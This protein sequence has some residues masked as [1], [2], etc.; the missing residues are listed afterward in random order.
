MV[1]V[2]D[3]GNAATDVLRGYPLWFP[4]ASL[5]PADIAA[6]I[7]AG[8]QAA[9]TATPEVRAQAARFADRYA[10]DNQLLPRVDALL[11]VA[12]ER[13]EQEST[14]EARRG[15]MKAVLVVGGRGLRSQW[16][17]SAHDDLAVGG[18]PVDITLVSWHLPAEPLPVRE[19][20]VIGPRLG[21]ARRHE[22]A[23]PGALGAVEPHRDD[24]TAAQADM[25]PAD[26]EQGGAPVPAPPET[27]DTSFVDDETTDQRSA[28]TPDSAWSARRVRHGLTW[29]AK[30]V[31]LTGRR[32]Y[33]GT[34]GDDPVSRAM[35]TVHAT[36]LVQR[37]R[38]NSVSIK[39]AI[40]V[41][42]VP[43]VLAAVRE[44]DVLVGVDGNSHRAVW[45]LARKV[46]GPPVVVGLPSARKVLQGRAQR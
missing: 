44:A 26:S 23:P 39:F 2:H 13:V 27:P 6:A 34:Y 45:A 37:L 28:A 3:P 4:A 14:E 7:T 12:H 11:G 43:G 17:R 38:A 9:R 36:G 31:R 5:A 10:R 15:T 29:R 25:S 1:S 40:G 22:V 16:V 20:W 42:T 18:A 41:G 30:R 21:R 32:L 33:R 35:R 19:H 24:E 46:H 8:A